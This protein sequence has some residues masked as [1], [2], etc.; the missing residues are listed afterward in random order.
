M[1]RHSRRIQR[2]RPRPTLAITGR[3]RRSLV[4]DLRH[5][6]T[7]SIDWSKEGGA[8]AGPDDDADGKHAAAF[9]SARSDRHHRA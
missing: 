2:R 6:W 3:D 8:P 4:Q 7:Q 1:I 9:V 5:L